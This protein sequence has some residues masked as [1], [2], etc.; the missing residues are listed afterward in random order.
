MVEDL[1]L[2]LSKVELFGW[3][4]PKSSIVVAAMV[5]AIECG[6][7][8]PRVFVVEKR[9]GYEL[10]YGFVGRS[11]RP[12]NYNY[13]GHHRAIAHYIAGTPLPCRVLQGHPQFPHFKHF[14][15]IRE[16][17]LKD[18]YDE[19]QLREVLLYL[20]ERQREIFIQNYCPGFE[21]FPRMDRFFK[22]IAN[23]SHLLIS[24]TQT[25]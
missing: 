4:K 6:A 20:P 21:L 24:N 11:E 2:D 23:Y 8:F 3:E 18:R 22:K 25:Q 9:R 10:A 1:T 16:V 15:N 12:E 17:P 19:K 14:E 5:S 13:G 7:I